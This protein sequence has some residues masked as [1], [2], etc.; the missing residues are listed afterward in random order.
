MKTN[1]GTP[2]EGSDVNVGLFVF[3]NHKVDNVNEPY[4]KRKPKEN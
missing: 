4:V 3:E 1:E 2:F